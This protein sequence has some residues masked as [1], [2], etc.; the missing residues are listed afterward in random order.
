[1]NI[2]EFS[3]KISQNKPIDDNTVGKIL[4]LLL[5]MPLEKMYSAEMN[6]I[7]ET[8]DYDPFAYLL[9]NNSIIADPIDISEF[10]LRRFM[11]FAIK[12]SDYNDKCDDYQQLCEHLALWHKYYVPF[13]YERREN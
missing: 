3:E 11:I 12:F 9:V 6:Y 10:T 7:P 2:S 13:K 4:E 5:D 1:M 8:G